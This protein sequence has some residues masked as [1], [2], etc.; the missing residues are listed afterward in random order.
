MPH[1]LLIVDI[2]LSPG[3]IMWVVGGVRKIGERIKVYI[4]L[5]WAL[6]FLRMIWCVSKWNWE[7]KLRDIP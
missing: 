7:G 2:K 4:R 1:P 5:D 6:Q 3:G